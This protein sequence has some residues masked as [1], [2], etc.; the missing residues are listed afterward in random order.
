MFDNSTELFISEWALIPQL[1]FLDF[2]HLHTLVS[3]LD[4]NDKCILQIP[5]VLHL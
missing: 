3:F 2:S 4:S 5:R 1:F